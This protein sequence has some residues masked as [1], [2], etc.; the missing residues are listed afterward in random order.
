M[1]PSTPQ[2]RWAKWCL[3][4]SARCRVGAELD[5]GEGHD[6]TGT[7]QATGQAIGP[8]SRRRGPGASGV[9]A[10]TRTKLAGNRQA[11]ERQQG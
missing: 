5:S 1:N 3:R 4:S 2:L 11:D 9:V 8:S 7:S 6:G 10:G